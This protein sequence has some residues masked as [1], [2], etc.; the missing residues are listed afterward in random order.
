MLH[1]AFTQLGSNKACPM[2]FGS[3]VATKAEWAKWEAFLDLDRVVS[4]LMS[5]MILEGGWL[6]WTRLGACRLETTFPSAAASTW[7]CCIIGG[8]GDGPLLTVK[9]HQPSHEFTFGVG[10]NFISY[11]LVLTPLV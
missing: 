10:M 7:S 5:L 11:P 4:S 2:F 3:K 9:F 8:V 1:M 6:T